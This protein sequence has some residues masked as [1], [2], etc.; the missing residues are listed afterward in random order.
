M[1]INEWIN[2]FANEHGIT[3]PTQI[4]DTNTAMNLM[5]LVLTA[6]SPVDWGMIGGNITNQTDLMQIV[7]ELRAAVGTPLVASTVADMTDTDKIYVYVGTESGYT[8]GNWY[9]YDGSAW[10]SGGVYNSTAFETDTTL[11]VSG[12]AADAK[13]VGDKFSE[14][15]GNVYHDEVELPFTTTSGSSINVDNG[16]LASSSVFSY[17]NYIDVELYAYVTYKQIKV[18]AVNTTVGIAFYDENKNFICGVYGLY[19]NAAAGYGDAVAAVPPRAKYLRATTFTDTDNRGYFSISGTSV[20]GVK[21]Y[22][23]IKPVCPFIK[24]KAINAKTGAEITSSANLCSDY[25]YCYGFDFIE[26]TM[27]TPASNSN[28]NGLHFYDENKSVIAHSYGQKLDV[29]ATQETIIKYCI[30]P[31]GAYFVRFTY[32]TQENI[33]SNNLPDFY[34]KL[35]KYGGISNANLFAYKPQSKGVENIIK[36]AHQLAN[37]KWTPIGNIEKTMKDLSDTIT[38]SSFLSG[39]EYIGIPYSVTN[40]RKQNIGVERSIDLFE[41]AIS[42]GRTRAYGELHNYAYFGDVCSSFVC[43]SMGLKVAPVTEAMPDFDAFY[44]VAPSGAFDEKSMML[45]NILLKADSHVA[46][47][48]GILTDTSASIKLIE[49]SEA[50][51]Y[52]YITGGKVQSNWYTP[53]QLMTRFSGYDLY[54][55]KFSEEV[56]YDENNYAQV[57]PEGKTY[58]NPKLLCCP[59]FG[60]GC[61]TEGSSLDIAISS[62][63][64]TDGFT[65]LKVYKDGTLLNTYPITSETTSVTVSTTSKGKYFAY[66]T[67]TE[68]VIS[69]PCEWEV[70]TG[71]FSA[72]ISGTDLTLTYDTDSVIYGIGYTANTVKY[73][74]TTGS[75]DGITGSGTKVF[76]VKSGASS[77]E[78]VYGNRNGAVHKSL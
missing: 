32:P 55:Y 7:S 27:F 34:A 33:I 48:T 72:S 38:Y 36:R 67:N 77:P 64:Y 69:V 49:V 70:I 46:L 65:N 52:G 3:L 21:T 45:G 24:N 13:V 18:T 51:L 35:V 75:L 58:Q 78:V 5:Q 61:I 71:T 74:V 76:S 12:A 37:V 63:A 59:V 17:T 1:T 19:G 2:Q 39:I 10:V 30:I 66:L 9:Y 68:N 8:S 42:N 11:S 20:V 60:N 40:N 62:S 16:E 44:K 25:V 22:E 56:L 23:S 6:D 57:Y 47:I 50:T 28:P 15:S 53:S 4:P 26:Y 41:S 43:A 54:R 14:L 31:E 29:S 73:Y